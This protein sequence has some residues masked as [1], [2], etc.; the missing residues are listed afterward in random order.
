MRKT[1]ARTERTQ[2]DRV[3]SEAAGTV[4]TKG[5]ERVSDNRARIARQQE[6]WRAVVGDESSG[7]TR[8]AAAARVT[9]TVAR[10]AAARATVSTL[11]AKGPA[12]FCLLYHY[13]E[14]AQASVHAKKQ[15]ALGLRQ[16]TR[17]LTSPPLPSKIVSSARVGWE[18]PPTGPASEHLCPHRPSRSTCR[19]AA[20]RRHRHAR[21]KRWRNCA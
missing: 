19:A 20:R 2:N 16:P 18:A 10:A 17:A 14:Y 15:Q 3:R 7:R 8:R 11:N 1:I 21:T 13:S 12:K 6:R 9:A 5:H 4:A